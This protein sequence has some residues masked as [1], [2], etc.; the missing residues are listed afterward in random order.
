MVGRLGII[1]DGTGDDYRKINKTKTLLNH[2][3][4]DTY[5][6]FVNTSLDVALERNQARE[7]TVPE[8]VTIKS[9]QDVQRNIGAFQ[10]TFTAQNFIIVD[11]NI[12]AKELVTMTMNKVSRFVRQLMSA[13]VKNYE[14]KKWIAR[15]LELKRR[16]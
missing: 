8:Y 6:I 14:A 9:W 16:K 5:M 12:S 11:N 10:N 13:P 4:Y 3:G 15:E 1:I 2:L 7:R